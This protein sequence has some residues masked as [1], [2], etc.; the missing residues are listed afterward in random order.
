MHLSRVQVHN[1]HPGTICTRGVFLP[2]ERCF[3]NFVNLGASCPCFRGDLFCSPFKR[4]YP[5][6]ASVWD[7]DG[8]ALLGLGKPLIEIQPCE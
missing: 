8:K 5:L 2:C 1:L 4:A 6:T 3:K 7:L